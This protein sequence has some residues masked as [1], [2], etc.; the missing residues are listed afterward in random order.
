MA[1]TR[2]PFLSALKIH[3][4]KK[5]NVN[6][7]GS[8]PENTKLGQFIQIYALQIVYPLLYDSLVHE[9]EQNVWKQEQQL[10]YLWPLAANNNE[11]N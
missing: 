8:I 2:T 9:Q 4:R 1:Q 11:S 3:S 7:I 10:N 5:N 6:W